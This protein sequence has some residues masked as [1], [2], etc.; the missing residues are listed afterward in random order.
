MTSKSEAK[1]PAPSSIEMLYIKYTAKC[2]MSGL[3]SGNGQAIDQRPL[4][5]VV[6]LSRITSDLESA[7][8]IKDDAI[9]TAEYLPGVPPNIL[10]RQHRQTTT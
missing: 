4:E 9:L 5:D 6:L 3:A 8:K 10:G 2:W 7:A 1:T